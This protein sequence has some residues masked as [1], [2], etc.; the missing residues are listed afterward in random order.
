MQANSV[1]ERRERTLFLV[2]AAMLTAVIIIMAFTP[3]GFLKVGIVEITFL[4]IP[5]AVGAVMMGW[6][7]GLL[8]G[9]VFGLVSFIQCF[10]MSALGVFLMGINPFLTFVVC[11]IPRM[12]TGFL[13]GLIF[14][15]VSKYEKKGSV[16]TCIVASILCPVFNTL[17]FVSAFSLCFGMN[18]EVLK[19]F[20]ES[21]LLGIITALLTFNALIEAGVC[22]VIGTAVSKALVVAVGRIRKAK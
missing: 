17:F 12:L 16:G 10:G 9:T 2:E 19:F 7:G 20:G 22:A 8:L 1:A 11:V 14:D 15:L 3:L 5:V 18:P 4:T 21:S 6:K 13:T